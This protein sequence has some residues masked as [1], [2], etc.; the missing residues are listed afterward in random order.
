[1]YLP[2]FLTGFNPLA[3]CVTEDEAVSSSAIL[4]FVLTVSVDI[5]STI[6]LTP[7]ILALSPGKGSNSAVSISHSL[8]LPENIAALKLLSIGRN[9]L[10]SQL[11]EKLKNYE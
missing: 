3:F 1:M 10:A 4:S 8:E 9:S 7:V 5:A 11:K 6:G 2:D